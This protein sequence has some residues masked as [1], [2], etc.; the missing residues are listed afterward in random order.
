MIWQ[1]TLV[2][3]PRFRTFAFAGGRGRKYLIRKLAEELSR[4]GK[5]VLIT[6]LDSIKL[7]VAGAIVVGQDIPVLLNQVTRT[8]EQESVVDA[9]KGLMDAMLVGFNL[10]ELQEIQRHCPADYLLI[11]LGGSQEK[12][13]V[14]ARLAKTWARTR[15]WD[16]FIFCMEIRLIDSQLT[17]Q[18]AEDFKRFSRDFDQTFTQETFLQ[19][20]LDESRGL[21]KLFKASWPILFLFTDVETTPLENRALALAKELYQKGITHLAL[22]NV[23]EN[24]IRKLKP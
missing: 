12:P 5:K 17:V 10:K 1:E 3:D 8:F 2:L 11:E 22:A 20:L 24:S 13:I 4:R 18:T 7:P 19:Y 21:G 23:K 16:Q 15:I 6:G 9:G 14:D